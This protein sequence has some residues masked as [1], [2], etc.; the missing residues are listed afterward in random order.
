MITKPPVPFGSMLRAIRLRW[1]YVPSRNCFVRIQDSKK[2]W[3]VELATN[4][5]S[6]LSNG[7]GLYR[8]LDPNEAEK[9]FKLSAKLRCIKTVKRAFVLQLDDNGS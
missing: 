3:K 5:L 8:D 2:G 7:K 9:L 1:C 4:S 6:D